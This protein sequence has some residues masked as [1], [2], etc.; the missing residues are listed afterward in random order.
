MSTANKPDSQSRQNQD[1]GQS[2]TAP[3]RIFISY[4]QRDEDF[5]LELGDHLSNLQRQGLVT[6]WHDRLIM[7]GQEWAGEIDAALNEA[8]IILLLVS[9]RFMAS[10]YCYAKE[11][12]RAIERH[13]AGEAVVIPILLSAC[14]WQNAPFSKLQ[15]LPKN[16]KPINKWPD[17]D[18]AWLDVV[19]GLRKVIENLQRPKPPGEDRS[20]G[21]IGSAGV[22]SSNNQPSPR[23]VTELELKRIIS[24]PERVMTPS[25]L[26]SRTHRLHHRC[27]RG[28]QSVAFETAFD[29][30]LKSRAHRPLVCL[31][32][33]NESECPDLML[34]RI[35]HESLRD[36][37]DAS[38]H[39]C[40]WQDPPAPN[41]SVEN[42]WL[43]L[44]K[45]FLNKRFK[46]KA[47][48]QKQILKELDDLGRP[49]LVRLEWYPEQFSASRTNGLANFVQFWESWPVLPEN[50]LVICALSLVYSESKDARS[51]LAFWRKSPAEQLKEWVT[52]Y[53]QGQQPAP[54]FSLAVLPELE[55]VKHH[56]AKGWCDYLAPEHKEQVKDQIIEF[57][58]RRQN[59]AV[60]MRTLV[61]ELKSLLANTQPSAQFPN[62]S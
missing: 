2:P 26:A 33:G 50:R 18:E 46:D 4:S 12:V 58:E 25:D 43:A 13:D 5:R 16:V 9:A 61:K 10:D 45:R 7:P 29:Q 30:H 3:V 57:F 20:A 11:M 54:S 24:E 23:P 44:G 56:E 48:S 36:L 14:D 31:V 22:A 35:Q 1:E 40:F 28:P 15:G 59:R 51:R 38:A 21:D 27:N 55:P 37:L 47:E 60:D 52:E 42:F 32:H 17:R 19:R 62:R 8:P 53:Q 39:D 6:G 49:L 41:D 34:D